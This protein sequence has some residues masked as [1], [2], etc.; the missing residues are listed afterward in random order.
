MPISDFRKKKL[1]YV[2]NVF[3]GKFLFNYW[4]DGVNCLNLKMFVKKIVCY[5]SEASSKLEPKALV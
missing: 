4:C 1:L 2:F 5:K 3:F